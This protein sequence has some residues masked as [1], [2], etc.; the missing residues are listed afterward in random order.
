[1][2]KS[3]GV[4]LILCSALLLIGCATFQPAARNYESGQFPAAQREFRAAWVATVANIN[5]PSEPGLSTAQQQE[6]A[7][8]LLDHLQYLNFNAVIFQ[9]RPQCDALYVSELEPWSYYLTG[10]QGQAPEPYYDPLEFWIEEAQRRGMELHAWLNPYRAHHVSGGP[11]SDQSIVKQKP[12]LVV[13]LSTGYWW[14]DPSMVRTQDHSLAVVMDIIQ[15]YDV[16]GIHFD[17]YFYPYPSYNDNQDFPDDSSWADYQASGGKLNRGDW[18][19]DG[20]NQFIQRLYGNIKKV[21]PHV[22][23][24]LSPFGIWR[25][26]YPE[27]ISGFDQYSKLYADAR[28]WLRQGW[29]DYWTPQLYW[30]VNRIPQSYP[31]LLGWWAGENRFGRHL[32]PGI[33]IGQRGEEGADETVNQIMIT[34]GMLPQSQGNVHW[35]FAPLISNQSLASALVKGPYRKPA[36]VPASPWLDKSPPA[37]PVPL[38]TLQDDQMKINWLHPEPADVFRWVLYFQYGKS[39]DYTILNQPDDTYNL[40]LYTLRDLSPEKLS[41]SDSLRIP[42]LINSLN[43]VRI[44]AVDRVGNESY[45]AEVSVP[46]PDL[47]TDLTLNALLDRYAM[48]NPSYTWARKSARL[49]QAYTT[50]RVY[51]HPLKDLK[52]VYVDSMLRLLQTKYP[53]RFQY[54]PVG[55]SVEKRPINLVKLGTGETRILL[56]SQM[57]GDEPTATAALFDVFNYLCANAD[58]QPAKSILENITIL[59]VP[60][61]NPDGAERFTRRNAQ[62]LDINR[63]ARNLQSPEGRVLFQ[64]Q[65]KYQ[66]DFGF[67]LHDMSTRE[68]VGETDKLVALALM[69]PPFNDKNDDN[70]V[71]TRAKQ[72]TTVI[73]DALN[74]FIEGHIAKYDADYMPRAFGDSMQ[75]WGVSTVLV[76]SAGWFGEADEFLQKINFIAYL[77]AFEAIA[78]GDYAIA[79][80]DRYNKLPLNGRDLYDLIIQDVA[81]IDGTGIPAFKAD[82]AVNLIDDS[83]RIV[84]LGDLDVF[85]AK[86]TINGENLYLTPGF[87]GFVDVE[88]IPLDDLVSV[89]RQLLS[90]GFTTLI[91]AL[92][93]QEK[94]QGARISAVLNESGYEG[95]WESAVKVNKRVAKPT[96]II[97]LLE[98]LDGCIGVMVKQN[99]LIADDFKKYSDK[100]LV[101][102]DNFFSNNNLSG[103][104]ETLVKEFTSDQSKRWALAGKGKIRS[105]QVADFVLLEKNSSGPPVVRAVYVSGKL[106]WSN[107]SWETH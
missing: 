2:F 57:H 49:D 19:R 24:G 25:P 80:P 33:N 16:D 97:E 20:V 23:F 79:D 52:Y 8:D 74:P 105:G 61:L 11:V 94:D 76:E 91:Y 93:Q 53:D 54:L 85:A 35:S 86:D 50:V 90:Q 68:T 38:A 59:A 47:A 15:R 81:V 34:R 87:I 67:N 3:A 82:I 95:N 55:E 29:I 65:E 44:T 31:V 43:A 69:A 60:M 27:S 32:W 13:Q 84:D 72:V 78:S 1:M 9:V 88:S 4:L 51:K 14:L 104:D 46:A 22:K 39:W 48:D 103:L 5:W 89:S 10:V 83:G 41:D 28:L 73:M 62:G 107:E 26:N 30:T 106:A 18:R 66:P 98:Q 64:L 63:D 58:L 40:P 36:L 99:S 12:E 7:I 45:F 37:P 96:A 6:E 56:W 77:A 70:R 17:D 102:I 71:R 42:E 100:P 75:N 92:S 101:E 21:K